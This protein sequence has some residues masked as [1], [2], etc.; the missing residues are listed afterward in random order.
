[1]Y[2]AISFADNSFIDILL[3]FTM[4]NLKV[5]AAGN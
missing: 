5:D 4:Q 1:M 3:K 2:R